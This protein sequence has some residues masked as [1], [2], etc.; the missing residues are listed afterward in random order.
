LPLLSLP[1]LRELVEKE[2]KLQKP[3]SLDPALRILNAYLGRKN[4]V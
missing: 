1:F 2:G 3:A 4:R